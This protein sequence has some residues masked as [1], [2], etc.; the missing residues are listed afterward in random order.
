MTDITYTIDVKNEYTE[1][2]EKEVKKLIPFFK[3]F[4]INI[5]I[6]KGKNYGKNKC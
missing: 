4:G 6:K 1:Y 2:W 3:K 5:T